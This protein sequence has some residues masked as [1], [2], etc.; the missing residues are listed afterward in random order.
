MIVAALALAGIFIALYLTL[1]KLGYLGEL[2]CAVGACDV[3]NAS[4]WATFMSFPVAA[5]GVGYYV[6]TFMVAMLGLRERWLDS[7]LIARALLF[8]GVSGFLFSAWLTYLELFVIHAICQWC[9]V[10]AVLATAI[11]VV[12]VLEYRDLKNSHEDRRELTE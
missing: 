6:A 10:S 7:M 5:W 12:S 2:V 8:L 4:R 11:F 9:V 3:V 1:H